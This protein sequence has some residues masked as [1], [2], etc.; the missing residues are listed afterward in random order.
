[1]RNIIDVMDQLEKIA[2]QLALSFR[3]VRDSVRYTAPEAF[4][5]RWR[6]LTAILQAEAGSGSDIPFNT[7]R[8][9]VNIFADK[10]E[11][12]GFTADEI[13]TTMKEQNGSN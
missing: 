13:A 10:P 2:P 6:D 4:G 7:R 8:R 12:T 9:L 3:S 1:M 5:Q 11:F